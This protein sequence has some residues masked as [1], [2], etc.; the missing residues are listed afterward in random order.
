MPNDSQLEALKLP[1]HS[2]EAEQSVLGGLL[3]EN[4]AADRI[5]D[6]LGGDDFYSDAHR[7]VFDAIMHL[8]ADNK[9][10]DV[11]TVAETLASLKKLDYIG[12][13]AYL[14]V[15]V[16]NV[17]TAANIRRYAEIVRERAILRR[18]AAAG[19]EIAD[20]A[21]NPMGRSV[22]EV[23]DQAETKVFEIAEHG[24]RGQQGFQEL[25]PLLTQAVERIELLFH[26]DN[27]SDVT[28]VPTGFTDLDRMTSGLQEGDLIVIAGRP[29]MGKAQP[30]DVRVKTLGGWKQMHQLVLG[31]ALASIDG[32]P[33]FV[34]GIFP[35]GSRQVF[36]VTFSDGRST[37]AC[38]EH[39]WRV[40]YRSWGTPKILSTQTVAAMLARKRYRGRLW[41]DCVS[42]DFGDVSPLPVDPWLLGALLGDGSLTG[43]CTRFSTTADAMLARISERI[44]PALVLQSA[45]GIDWRIVQRDRGRRR[46]TQGTCANPLTTAIKSFGL[47]G[48]RSYEKFVPAPYLTAPRQARLDLLRGLLDTDGWIERCGT[49]RFATSSR[50]LAEDVTLLARSLGAWCSIREKIPSYSYQA[51][52]R[53]GRPSYVCTLHHP[54]P[55]SLFLL[56][57]KQSLALNGPKRRKRPNFVSIEPTRITQT[58]CISVTHPSN[59][60]VT[61]D[62]VVTHN[63]AL[64]LN[65]GEHIALSSKLPVAIF[66]MEMGSMQLAM[67][68]IGSV[69][70]VDQHKVR[71]G[72][73][74]PDDWGRLSEALGR[75]S[76]AAIHVDETP[77]LNALELRA[78][79]RRLARQYG[80]KLGV[81]V[82]DYLQLM[83][84]VAQGE[85]RATEISEISRS[86]K[87]LAKE[88]KV[89]V[90]ALSQLN[91]SLEQRPNKRP[92]M[93]DLRECVT[94]DTPVL[95]V[96]GRRVP[97]RE[98]VG[99]TPEVWAMSAEHT[100]VAARSD[101][102]WPVGVRPVFRIVLASGRTIR[103]TA[104]HRLYG[105][106]G[107]TRA[108]A[109]CVG[110]RVAL[111]R[112]LPPPR[113]PV[114]WPEHHV[115]LLGQL[116]GD[117]SYLNHQPLLYTTAS[118]E[119]S[120][121]VREAAEAFGA[122]VRR[123]RGRGLWHQLLIS[124]NG[125]RW[126][127]QGV[128][129]W[130]RELGVFNQ[131]SHEKRLP[132]DV[133]RFSN[134]QIALLLRHLWATAGSIAPRRAGSNGADRIYFSTSSPGLGSDVSA[135]L[136]RLGIVARVRMLAQTGYRPVYSV[137]V[138][139]SSQQ[140]RFLDTVGAFGPR[141]GPALKLRA[142]LDATTP[143]TR[144]DAMPLEVFQQ[145][146]SIMH[147]RGISRRAVAARRGSACGGSSHVSF[148]PSRTLPSENA[149]LLDT[150]ELSD[151]AR[152]DVFWDRVVGIASDGEAEVFDLTV[153]GPASWLADGIVNH[154]SGAIEQDADV[155]LFIYR[156]EV[157]NEDTQDKGV[158]E[159]IIGK[160]RNGPIGS[161]R[162]AF[163]GQYTRFENLAQAGRF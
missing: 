29:S 110:D 56:S 123:C 13:M 49:I 131:R 127:P 128:N 82:V 147:A 30:L 24:A 66:S 96:D 155:I 77:A 23:L 93:S 16:E 108:D 117:G 19:G 46:G 55:K 121:A 137:D 135:L 104:R 10:A 54:E 140:L 52:H 27:P 159:I 105:G 20:A 115:V 63:T 73:L 149:A 106:G 3:L 44:E 48:K 41:I 2:P 33:S 141:V 37:E 17:P 75:L 92:I 81:I 101:R 83:Q 72:Q 26:R 143:N 59:L 122:K 80:G 34:S 67:R 35:Q 133:F 160:Q 116:V 94:G 53:R 113:V 150:P 61:D 89:P 11:V 119:N 130:L 45:G 86:L 47:W 136:L 125:N 91:R 50:R 118:D 38:G 40:N 14:G 124:G 132:D 134:E 148:A 142:V 7:A 43:S 6:I 5:G 114:A 12:G 21:Y 100:I 163:L 18:L 156:D 8:I 98:L 32:Q 99:T 25:R 69:G 144:V 70:R 68:L 39:L 88:L 95:L 151:L 85:N 145:A 138:S 76:E 1:P 4:G 74:L 112:E 58:Q 65:I 84:A 79:A 60:Y 154:N 111:A 90:M 51:E 120:R 9:P 139:G 42:G 15:L 64:A 71:T 36:R 78:R 87:A 109:L 31:E 22:R 153:P 146:K 162:L 97:I 103:V 129:R 62:Y 107:W 102:V 158:A 161:I 157:Y 152:S 126:A 57:E 28:G